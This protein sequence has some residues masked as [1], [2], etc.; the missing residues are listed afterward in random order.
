MSYIKGMTVEFDAQ[1]SYVMSVRVMNVM[2]YEKKRNLA[3]I[4]ETYK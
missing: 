3:T 4:P 1:M 2:D